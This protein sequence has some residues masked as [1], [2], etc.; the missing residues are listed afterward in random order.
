MTS[1]LDLAYG[2]M[3]TGGEADQLRFYRVLADATLFLLLER[4]AEG[5]VIV[6]RVFD[7]PDGPVL[8][9]FDSEDRLAAMGD[10]PLPYAALPGRIIAQQMVGQ[11]LSLGLNL[12]T[13]AACETLLP[14]EAMDWLTE[15]LATAPSA[16]E[17]Q[18]A[19]FLAPQGLPPVL[20]DALEAA[21]IGV[22]G[23]AQA[24]LL[25]AVQYKDGRRGHMLAVVGAQPAAHPALARAMGE[26]LT[27][28]GVEAGELDVTFLADQDPGLAALLRV[29]R[30]FEVPQPP[31]PEAALSPKAPG[32]DPDKPP[33]LR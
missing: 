20:I 26:A 27:F 10:G 5:E 6:P 8:L 33:M 9:A 16:V 22:S 18:V 4:E 28:S 24:G 14:P 13:D 25:A 2:R 23:L 19:Q 21:M 7:L 30:V 31:E 11:G 12:G 1:E 15:M 32:S 17:A 3:T 29:A